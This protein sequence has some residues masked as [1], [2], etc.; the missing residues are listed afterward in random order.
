MAWCGRLGEAEGGSGRKPDSG[1]GALRRLRDR[2]ERP[3][4][5]RCAQEHAQSLLGG[6]PA[7]WHG[8]V[9]LAG[10]LDAGAERLCDQGAQRGRCRCG[11][12]FRAHEQSQARRERHRAFLSGNI[13][14][15]RLAADL[16]ARHEQ[17]DGPRCVRAQRIERRARAGRQ[18][19]SGRRV[20][21]SL[22]RGDGAERAVM[23]RVAAARMWA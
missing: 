8:S 9:R 13:Q 21:R 2:C 11:R 12:E 22:R 15:T 6:R 4:L 20:D 10:C 17:G 19:G 14:R 7:G 18:R 1:T 16:D 23:C 3:G 5:R